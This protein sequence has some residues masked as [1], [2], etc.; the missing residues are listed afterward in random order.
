MPGMATGLTTTSLERKVA[1]RT[2]ALTRSEQ[3]LR[4]AQRIARLGSY[5]F[6]VAAGRWESSAVLDELF[7][8]DE[9]YERTPQGWAAMIHPDDAL[10]HGHG[11]N[12]E[13]LARAPVLDSVF[14][15]VRRSDRAERWVH[16]LGQVEF[17]GQGQALRVHG[18]IQD[19]TERKE[20]E[21]RIRQMAFHDELTA[22]PNRRLL[23]DRLCQTL[24]AGKRSASYGA[25]MFLD[26]DNFKPL[27]DRYGHAVGDLLLIEAAQRLSACV[28]KADTVSRFGGDEF[29]VMLSELSHSETESTEQAR[30]VAE[31]IRASLCAP[32]QLPVLIEGQKLAT[33][34]YRCSASIGVLVFN[35]L[36]S[37]AN[38]VLRGAD[39]AMYRA[40]QAG[41]NVVR[42]AAEPA[43]P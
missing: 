23:N 39:L 15:I 11:F 40:K 13:L 26:L 20:M 41:R 32:Y 1:Q 6:D 9:A 37:D 31:K 16:G 8:I 17:D 10:A 2:L 29:V 34:E 7:G 25:L 42:L 5:V 36:S 18:T 14:R 28:R 12:A 43:L 35:C 27:N 19:I 3:Q 24:I 30:V 38:E 21:D 33:I 22:L 4:D